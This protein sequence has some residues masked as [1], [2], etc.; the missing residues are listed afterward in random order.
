MHLSVALMLI[1]KYGFLGLKP[2]F[3]QAYA[4]QFA[5]FALITT[6]SSFVLEATKLVSTINIYV[7]MLNKVIR[8]MA[9]MSVSFFTQIECIQSTTG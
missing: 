7:N 8:T 2:Y 6:L 5:A 1:F 9:I 3:W 4:R